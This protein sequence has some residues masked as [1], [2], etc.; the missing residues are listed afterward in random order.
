M[1]ECLV[2]REWYYLEG[3][4]SCC[5]GTVVAFWRNC[6]TSGWLWGLKS[7]SQVQSLFL[8]LPVDPDIELSATSPVPCLPAC[9]QTPHHVKMG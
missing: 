5:F 9:C 8:A 6:V 4:M 7:P 1:F 3:F 2:I